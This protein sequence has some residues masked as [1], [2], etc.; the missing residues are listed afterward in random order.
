MVDFPEICE[1]CD[2]HHSTAEHV[3]LRCRLI[4]KNS[5]KIENCSVICKICKGSHQTAEHKCGF[6]GMKGEN[7]H[8]KKEC[9]VIE[10]M[11]IK[12]SY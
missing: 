1:I 3:C 10:K 8:N 9:N 5:H 4:G 6:C 12:S 7:S 2:G 11:G